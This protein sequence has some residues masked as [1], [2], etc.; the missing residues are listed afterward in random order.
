VSYDLL[1]RER[2]EIE[3]VQLENLREMV[4]LCAT[5]HPHYRSLLAGI[6]IERAADLAHLPLT[7]K[8]DY[9]A[10]PERFA[11]DTSG[12]DEES[13]TVWDT[14]YTTGSTA[15]RPTPFVSTAFDFFHNLAVQRNMLRLRGVRA[16]DVIANLFPLT[17]APHGAWIRALH[18]AASLSVR[19]VAAMLGNPSPYFTTGNALDEVVRIVERSRATILWGVPSYV[20]RV[21]ERAAELGADFGAVRLAFVTGEGLS[22]TARDAL[23]Q[24]FAAC[25]ATASISISY[26][27]TEMQG[28]MV[29]CVPGAGYHNPAPDQF[30][31]EIVDPETHTTL[32]D[33][34]SG[35]VALTHLKRR[36]TVLLRYALGDVSVRTRE[37]CPHCGAWTDRLI[38]RPQRADALVKIKG[39]LVNPEA[40]VSALDESLAGR[41]YRATVRAVDTGS[42][43]SDRLTIEVAGTVDPT[44]A[45]RARAAC[46]NAIGVTPEVAW[47]AADALVDPS[48]AW[49]SKKFVDARPKPA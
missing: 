24:R 9:M 7:R 33:G 15:G 45:E 18:A 13:R 1:F 43:A 22:E 37:R 42:L 25:G 35:L 19:V 28:G 17:R 39:M 34:E 32:P 48:A 3:R 8:A 29:E 36:G 23:V 46:K 16:D 27:A 5:R 20:A 38:A 10:A 49:K 21:A 26:G 2:A 6:A 4:A 41:G 31:I 40:L 11:L 30:L 14:M 47:V 12:L 44:L